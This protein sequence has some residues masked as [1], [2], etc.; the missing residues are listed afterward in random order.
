VRI[1]GLTVVR[2]LSRAKA[3]GVTLKRSEALAY[4]LGSQKNKSRIRDG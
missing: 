4:G 2:I 3:L 1:P